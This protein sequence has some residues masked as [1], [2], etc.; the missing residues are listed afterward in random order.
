MHIKMHN[1]NRFLIKTNAC[2]FGTLHGNCS[3]LLDEAKKARFLCLVFGQP[4]RACLK[5]AP[6]CCGPSSR[7][8]CVRREGRKQSRMVMIDDARLERGCKGEFRV[9]N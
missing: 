8:Y 7:N 5:N 3:E 1:C 9:E 6:S 4:T 2:H